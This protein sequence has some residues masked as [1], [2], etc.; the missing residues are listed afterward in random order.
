MVGGW[1]GLD[2]VASARARVT[3]VVG[4]HSRCKGGGYVLEP[5]EF[6]S[7]TANDIAGGKHSEQ[8]GEGGGATAGVSF[9]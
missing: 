1:V 4:L 2:M 5:L 8:G 9:H 6:H 3:L 7:S